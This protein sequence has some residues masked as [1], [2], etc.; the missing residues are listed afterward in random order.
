MT[1]RARA[2]K[3]AAFA[4]RARRL[5]ELTGRSVALRC[6]N[7]PPAEPGGFAAGAPRRGPEEERLDKTLA[8]LPD[9]FRSSLHSR[10]WRL[11]VTPGHSVRC[12]ILVEQPRRAYGRI[13][14]SQNGSRRC[15]TSGASPA[16]PGD[17]QK[18]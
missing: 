1:P 17:L 6:T 9:S 14:P 7:N 16:E 11:D 18:D 4:K 15:Q 13:P 8:P 10:T 3:L 5:T 2:R 12:G